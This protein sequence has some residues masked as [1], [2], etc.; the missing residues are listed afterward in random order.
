MKKELDNFLLQVAQSLFRYN[1]HKDLQI[2][3]TDVDVF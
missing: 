2:L 1:T 3:H